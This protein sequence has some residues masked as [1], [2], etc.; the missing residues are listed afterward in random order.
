[1]NCPACGHD[2]SAA[3]GLR[4]SFFVSREVQSLNAHRGNYG[5]QRW[6]YAK[7]RDAWQQ[8]FVALGRQHCVTAASG[9]RRVT[10]TRC[11]S[12]RQREYDVDNL[13]GGCKSAVDAMRR[14]KLITGDDKRGA[15]ILYRQ[16]KVATEPGL[17]VV[18]EELAA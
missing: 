11:Y 3:I 14:A 1:M 5:G 17:E 2:P 10:L 16:R 18:I 12:G 7:D 6:A 9:K 8:W 13:I 15:E 4:W